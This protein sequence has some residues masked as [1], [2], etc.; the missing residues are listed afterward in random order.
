[1]RGNLELTESAYFDMIDGKTAELLACALPM[2]G[3][4]SGASPEVVQA[5]ARFGR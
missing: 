5:P 4:S 2:G 1:M 3:L